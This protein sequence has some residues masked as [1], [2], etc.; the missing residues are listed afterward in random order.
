M[1]SFEFSTKP[2][3]RR[4]EQGK[5]PKYIMENNSYKFLQIRNSNYE[6]NLNTK[7]YAYKEEVQNGEKTS[8]SC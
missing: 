7:N 4:P 8:I 3:K 2:F 6:E 5:S 1:K